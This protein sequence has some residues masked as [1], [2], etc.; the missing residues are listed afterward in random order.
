[1][2]LFQRILRIIQD[3]FK[4]NRATNFTLDSNTLR[5]LQSLA[6]QEQCTPEE[7]AD[8][9]LG[10]AF[11]NHLTQGENWQ[12]WQTLTPR[13][14]EIAA[15]ICLK[16]TSRQIADKLH[17]SPET[18]KTHVEHILMKFSASDR[19]SLRLMLNGWDFKAWDC[20]D[21]IE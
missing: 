3:W 2:V 19:N 8:Q 13:E 9:I 18:V 1:M 10:E 4:A 7:I 15:L 14:R 11:R 16:Y 5:S 20:Q 12:H 21:P 6:E 17:I